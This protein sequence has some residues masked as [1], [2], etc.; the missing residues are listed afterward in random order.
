MILDG[1]VGNAIDRVRALCPDLLEQNKE[2]ALLLNCQYFVEIYA[3]ANNITISSV[4]SHDSSSSVSPK[5]ETRPTQS[6]L[7]AI[8]GGDSYAQVYSRK[9]H[10]FTI[11][12]S[13]ENLE[14]FI[15]VTRRSRTGNEGMQADSS[16]FARVQTSNTVIRNMSV[17]ESV[18][19]RAGS[20]H[21]SSSNGAVHASNGNATTSNGVVLNG[22]SQPVS[23]ATT[24]ID[25]D[26][27]PSYGDTHQDVIGGAERT[28]TLCRG[29]TGGDP[30]DMMKCEE[31]DMLLKLGR[32]IN[33]LCQQIV[34]P[35]EDLVRRMHDILALICHTKPLDTSLRYLLE[36]VQ[37]H[38]GFPKESLLSMHFRTARKL[39]NDLSAMQLGVAVFADVDKLVAQN[40]EF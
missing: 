7:S 38:M 31:I 1:E 4:S 26:Q 8:S 15:C 19:D 25:E 12:A 17:D 23:S 11:T 2:L 14:P 37:Q 16:R 24:I 22:V 27:D 5:E 13:N 20:D 32:E 6:S 21:S 28:F 18:D 29:W 10:P 40:L 30:K 3:K 9:G 33:F 35:P 39:R 34:N 36:Q